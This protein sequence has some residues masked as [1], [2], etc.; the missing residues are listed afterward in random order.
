MY[1]IFNHYIFTH[2]ASTHVI[3]F[4]IFV[5]RRDTIWQNNGIYC[6]YTCIW[7]FECLSLS[8]SMFEFVLCVYIIMYVM[9]VFVC[10]EWEKDE[11]KNGNVTNGS[12][13]CVV[14]FYGSHEIHGINGKIHTWMLLS[15]R[16]A[17]IEWYSI[18]IAVLW[19]HEG[20]SCEPI[21]WQ[22]GVSK[23]TIQSVNT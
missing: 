7:V 17:H 4:A 16:F 19:A 18:I 22:Q 6:L 14:R 2:K 20:R 12:V 5:D 10:V 15:F 11:N 21:V 23:L 9:Y 13:L 1:K 3:V 8:L